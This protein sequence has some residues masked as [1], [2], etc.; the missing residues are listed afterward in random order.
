M[1]EEGRPRCPSEVRVVHLAMG[2]L[3]VNTQMP[4]DVSV[5][6]VPKVHLDLMDMM[7]LKPNS[8]SSRLR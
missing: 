8:R 7:A 5:T 3:S 6:L 1:T 2:Q 4:P